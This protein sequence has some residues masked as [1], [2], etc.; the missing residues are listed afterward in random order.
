MKFTNA[1]HRMDSATTRA[2]APFAQND[3]EA[4]PPETSA[5]RVGARRASPVSSGDEAEVSR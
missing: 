2:H 4:L 3:G 5:V 1:L